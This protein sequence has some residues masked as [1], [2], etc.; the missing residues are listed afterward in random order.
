MVTVLCFAKLGKMAIKKCR[1]H[2]QKRTRMLF[3]C[4]SGF[5]S[6]TARSYRQYSF[7]F[8]TKRFSDGRIKAKLCLLL[9]LVYD[10]ATYTTPKKVEGFVCRERGF[11][12]KCFQ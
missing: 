2:T 6:F 8:L 7:S 11:S 10:K 1:R 5:I 12:L 4:R 9:F 3:M